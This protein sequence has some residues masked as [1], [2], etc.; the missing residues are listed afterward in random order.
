MSAPLRINIPRFS[1][2]NSKT[3]YSTLE[4]GGGHNEKLGS[5]ND[6]SQHPKS[7][8]LS[9][10]RGKINGFFTPVVI[11]KTRE[12]AKTTL[13]SFICTLLV[14]IPSTRQILGRSP[15]MAPSKLIGFIDDANTP[16]KTFG[17]M[18]ETV[19][20]TFLMVPIFVLICIFA[21]LTRAA[22]NKRIEEKGLS[23]WED[24]MGGIVQ[25]MW[26]WLSG[27]MNLR[28]LMDTSLLDIRELLNALVQAFCDCKNLEAGPLQA[29]SDA[30]KKV[31]ASITK[32]RNLI[33]EA[34]LEL[35]YS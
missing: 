31:R 30:Q 16:N 10:L 7:N 11:T 26:L 24:R 18:I 5:E 19:L 28:T 2:M 8:V 13:A 20:L 14:M 22:Q 23:T 35:S 29:I 15:Q 32:L 21:I 9:E 4:D 3:H 34:E 25:I 33:W 6:V 1:S 27:S 12:V 17:S